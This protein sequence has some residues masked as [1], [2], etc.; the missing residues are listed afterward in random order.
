MSGIRGQ[1]QHSPIRRV[2]NRSE[3]LGGPSPG[4][5]RDESRPIRSRINP[6]CYEVRK[7][8]MLLLSPDS[9]CHA[10]FSAATTC[11]QELARLL[12]GGLQVIIDRLTGLFAQFKSNRSAGFLCRTV[13][14]SAV[15]PLAA[16]SSTLIATTS[17]PRSLLSIARL[18]MARSRARPS[19][20][21][22]VRIAQTCLGRNG[23][24]APVSLPSFQGTRLRIAGVAFS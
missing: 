20:W 2:L 8:G 23:G 10:A 16:T 9:S 4:E 12:V 3:G 19:I 6:A 24:L 15:Y 22:F 1:E 18:N 14:R 13:A 11:E 21:S 5:H 17:H 7:G